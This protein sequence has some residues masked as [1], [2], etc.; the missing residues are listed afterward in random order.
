MIC[1]WWILHV[2]ML[3][4][5]LVRREL[6]YNTLWTEPLTSDYYNIKDNKIRSIYYGFFDESFY[7]SFFPRSSSS[8][9][10]ALQNRWL[11]SNKISIFLLF[12][13]LSFLYIYF[14]FVIVGLLCQVSDYLWSCDTLFLACS[15][16]RGKHCVDVVVINRCVHF[17]VSC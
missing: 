13:V 3:R 12:R 1:L 2:T 10:S 16:V 9:T 8:G 4:F 11:Y 17:F 15:R 5:I 6:F 14:C 7:F